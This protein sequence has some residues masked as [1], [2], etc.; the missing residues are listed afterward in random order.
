M[1]C[2]RFSTLVSLVCSAVLILLGISARAHMANA[3]NIPGRTVI[4]DAGHGGFDPGAVGAHDTNEADINLDIA[5]MLRAELE[6]RGYS[7][8]LTRENKDALGGTKQ[9]DMQK[10]REII[11]QSGA[12]YTVSIHLNANTDRSCCGPVVL[13]HPDSQLGK[14]LAETL[15]MTLN[16]DLQIERPR[17]IQHGSYFILN[18]GAMPS[19]IIECGFITNTADEAKLASKDY[20][21]RVAKAIAQGFDAFVTRKTD[22]DNALLNAKDGR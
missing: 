2:R 12:D 4:V 13:Y 3:M 19:V 17:T 8:I 10:R 14:Q 15:Q 18:S 16:R 1:K 7:V 6:A 21:Q 9:A 22:A 5:F 11:L 20:Q